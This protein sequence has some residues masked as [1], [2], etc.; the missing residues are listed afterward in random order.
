MAGRCG[1]AWARRGAGRLAVLAVVAL[2]GALGAGCGGSSSDS[3]SSPA[4]TTARDGGGA[5]KVEHVASDRWTYARARFKE[6]CAGCHTLADAGANGPRFDLDAAP[7]INDELIRDTILHGGPGMP[8]FASSISYR[9][10]EQ[11]TAYILAV[12]GRDA[13][14]E[15]RWKWQ[16][17]LRQDGEVHRPKGWPPRRD[18]TVNRYDP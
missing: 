15:D 13:R 1:A 12:A 10:F 11:L 5:V 7:D 14:T 17:R 9:E 4:S 18:L 6:M 2:V 8:P 16:I 3:S